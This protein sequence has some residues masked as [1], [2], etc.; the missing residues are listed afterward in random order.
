MGHSHGYRSGTRYAFARPH[1]KHGHVLGLKTYL[2]GYRVGDYVDVVMNGT[3]H[4]G[5]THKTYHGRTGIVFNVS[6]RAVGVEINKQVRNR[7]IKKRV[8]VR[9]EHVRQS[10]CRL[11]FL[12]RVTK[13][14]QVRC[15]VG[16]SSRAAHGTPSVRRAVIASLPAR[17][18]SLQVKAAAKKAGK[19]VPIE[20]IKRFPG[21]PR[22][23]FTV[24]AQ[25]AHGLPELV[26]PAA[27]D[28]ML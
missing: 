26:A 3:F 7:I 12:A 28:E 4:K 18:S 19:P 13:N 22:A 23:G 15:T 27:F 2:T 16:C 21:A 8:N 17:A 5:M 11:D 25:S 20:A 9:V 14:E 10:K 24:S 6:R 1:R